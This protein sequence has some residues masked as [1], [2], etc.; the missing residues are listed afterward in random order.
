MRG[1]S[2]GSLLLL[3]A[4][5]VTS[6]LRAQSRVDPV[7]AQSQ[8]R[9]LSAHPDAPSAALFFR[10]QMHGKVGVAI[11]LLH[12]RGF[13]LSLPVLIELHN[14]EQRPIPAQYWR[15]RLS[16]EL[17]HRARLSATFAHGMSILLEHQSDHISGPPGGW[18]QRNGF[19]LRH[20]LTWSFAAGSLT[21]S[22]YA[23]FH[24]FS[25]TVDPGSCARRIPVYGTVIERVPDAGIPG[26]AALEPVI[27]AMFDGRLSAQWGYFVA[28]AGSWLLPHGVV[29]SEKRAVLDVGVR[30]RRARMGTLQL[31]LTC[32]LGD[33]VG[34]VR[35]RS[36]NG[37]GIGLRWAL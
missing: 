4:C 18:T 29:A 33:D 14:A 3:A 11:P 15:G 19:A 20:D 31:Y 35:N 25:C 26:N 28:L 34:Y 37:A 27:E 16:L 22:A 21:T 36:A 6:S 24:L 7:L 1:L 30:L 9:G 13:E 17:A 2:K 12:V 5:S 8:A 10:G 32:A 23:R